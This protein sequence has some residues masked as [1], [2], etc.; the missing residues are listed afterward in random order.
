MVYLHVLLVVILPFLNFSLPPKP[1]KKLIWSDEF[2]YTGLPDAKKWKHE[3][4]YVRNKEMQY[5]T[6]QRLENAHVENGNLVIEARLDSVQINDK[7]IPVTSASLTTQGIAEWQYGRIEVRAKIPSA[8]GTWPAIWMLGK[9][10]PE[11]GWPAGGE[12]DIMEHVG[13]DSEFIHT[14][15]H[16]KAYNHIKKTNKGK[17]KPFPQPYKDFHVYAIDWNKSKIDFFIDDKVV[18]TFRNEG[19]GSDVWPYDQPFYLIL[20]LAIGGGWGGTK[21]VDMQAFPHKF[22]IDYV[23]I[24]QD[25]KYKLN[26]NEINED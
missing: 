19:T 23:R 1:K 8:R 22:Y 3:E 5:Y 13:Y 15:I 9:N 14:N 6:K 18:F 20:N 7:I 2:N 25:K 21:G 26:F 4:G 10:T 17:A 11:A 24:Y 12:I 16:T